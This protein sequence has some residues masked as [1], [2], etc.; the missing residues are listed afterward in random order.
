VKRAL[1]LFG[2]MRTFKECSKYLKQNLLNDTEYDIFIHTW[3]ENEAKTKSHHNEHMDVKKFS[4]DEKNE[5][6]NIYNPKNIIIETQI[7]DDYDT[8]CPNNEINADGQRNM[9]K[10]L[11]MVN[12]L[13]KQYEIENNFTYDVVLKMRPDILLMRKFKDMEIKNNSIFIAGN[14]LGY[15]NELSSY[16][17]LDILGYCDSQTMDVVCDGYN[18]FEKFWMKTDYEH[19]AFIDYLLD[20]KIDINIMKYMYNID[21]RILRKKA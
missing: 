12:Q 4:E 5:I 7:V 13:K 8:T 14:K 1:L 16:K 6:K 19:S 15:P 9:I 2:H 11:F 17:A 18:H 21:W 20:R 10:S 3:D